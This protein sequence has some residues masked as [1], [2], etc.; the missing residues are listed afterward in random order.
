MEYKEQTWTWTQMEKFFYISNQE[1][2]NVVW[3]CRI[4]ELVNPKILQEL[5]DIYGVGI[6]ATT[7]DVTIM[8]LAGWFGYLCGAI[9]FLSSDGWR[10]LPENIK[11]QIYE[12]QRGTMMISFVLL[13]EK[14][15]RQGDREWVVEFYEEIMTPVYKQMQCMSNNNS[16]LQM[17]YQA[18]H[19]LYWISDRMKYSN[20]P[21]RSVLQYKKN[22]EI[23]QEETPSSC[24]GV[25][26][27]KHPYAKKLIFIDNPWDLD[28]P[29]PL[30][31]SCCLAY[32]TEGGH[33][34]YTCPR[35]KKS[36]RQDNFN[37]VLAQHSTTK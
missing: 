20:L 24:L 19:S 35:M 15:D 14:L 23:F 12:S 6:K 25:M 37:K 10:V 17:W 30:K 8:Y 27:A 1:M 32:Q 11:L 7:K 3:E 18:A 34:C 5:L 2:K 9:H 33:L 4:S 22:L 28:D 16:I 13:S 21:G 26:T 36:E 31:P 29:M